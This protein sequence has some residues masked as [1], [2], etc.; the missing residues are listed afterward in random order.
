[1]LLLKLNLFVAATYDEKY[2][3]EVW[4]RVKSSSDPRFLLQLPWKDLT[5][6]CL[7]QDLQSLEVEGE[8]P[9][10]LTSLWG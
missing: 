7:H 4:G 5:T 9:H 8:D 1:M 2:L 10:H 6:S 3:S